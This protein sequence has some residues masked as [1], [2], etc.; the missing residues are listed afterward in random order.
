MFLE[1]GEKLLV[2]HRRLFRNDTHRFFCGEVEH[3]QDGIVLIEG[4]T[5]TWD[6]MSGQMVKKEDRRRKLV[7]LASGT[8]IVY[9]LDR[10]V[11]IEALGFERES[12]G[13]LL[14]TDGADLKL[15]LTEQTPHPGSAATWE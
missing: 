2:T 12:N 7:A 1:Q 14:L 15:D 11:D 10:T 9:A 6:P 4:Y 5:W 3:Y 13:R 8:V